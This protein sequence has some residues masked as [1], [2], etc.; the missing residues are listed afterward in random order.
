MSLLEG[1]GIAGY[2]RSAG[3]SIEHLAGIR[4]SDTLLLPSQLSA[5]PIINTTLE[6]IDDYVRP[7]PI[8]QPREAAGSQLVRERSFHPRNLR[9]PDIRQCSDSQNQSS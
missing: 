2:S 9:G 3:R 1:M 8:K 5:S 4:T 7:R 6:H